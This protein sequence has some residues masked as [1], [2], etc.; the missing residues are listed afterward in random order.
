M[1]TT[2]RPAPAAP[3]VPRGRA[4]IAGVVAAAAA[5]A[6]GELVAALLP[7]AP[8]PLAAVGAAVIDF[9]PP[10][11]KELMVSLFGTA[12]K[13]ALGVLLTAVVLLAGAG[14]GL[15]A[16]RSLLPAAVGIAVIAGVGG[17]ID[18]LFAARGLIP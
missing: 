3:P 15:V 14:I 17:D 12:D 2:P 18:C 9:A 7:G 1:T 6:T 13:L 4:A 8:S 16:R 5:L 11:S 10:G